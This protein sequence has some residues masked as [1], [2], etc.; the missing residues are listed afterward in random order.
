MDIWLEFNYFQRP[1]SS[2]RLEL[3]LE[4]EAFFKEVPIDTKKNEHEREQDE[5]TGKKRDIACPEEA[6]AKAVD[7]IENGVN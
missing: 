5:H 7:E 3:L 1:R 4:T 2:C 6:V